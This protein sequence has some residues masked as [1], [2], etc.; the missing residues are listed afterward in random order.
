MSDTEEFDF[1]DE[2]QNEIKKEAETMP[3]QEPK[4]KKKEK[5]IDIEPRSGFRLK[6][7]LVS[8]AKCHVGLK[9][10]EYVP[11]KD[12]HARTRLHNSIHVG[13]R[14]SSHWSTI[15]VID[16]CFPQPDF[17]VTRLTDMRGTHIHLYIT[18]KAF[19]KYDYATGLG[20]IIAIKRPFLLKPTETDQNIALH[21]EQI[22]QMWIIGQSLDLVQCASHVRKDTQCQEWTDIRSGDYCD[23]HLERV[24]GYSKNGRMELA[25]G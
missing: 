4:D 6:R 21:V 11:L 14:P 8:N 5:S 1:L 23:K 7:R 15:G 18:G 19:E 25:S 17:C 13:V 2:L 20:S 10:V 9:N 16:K 24:Y 22:Q 12:V 3:Q